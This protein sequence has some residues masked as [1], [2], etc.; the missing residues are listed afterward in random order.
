LFQETSIV[1][2]KKA[3]IIDAVFQH[4]NA[5]Y[6]KPEG[7]A[8]V[9]LRTLAGTFVSVVAIAVIAVC[10]TFAANLQELRAEIIRLSETR[11]DL[12]RRDEFNNRCGP[13][14]SNGPVVIALK[15][16]LSLVQEQLKSGEEERKSLVHEVQ[17]LHERIAVMASQLPANSPVKLSDQDQKTNTPS[18][19]RKQ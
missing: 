6:T 8:S 9:L 17:Q 15:E 5:F 12:V 16:K 2:K 1:L 13:L 14:E 10:Q 3:D 7:K 4:R 11:S 18:V 19:L